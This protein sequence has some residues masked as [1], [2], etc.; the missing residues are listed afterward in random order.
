MLNKIAGTIGSRLAV[1]LLSLGILLISAAFIGRVGWGTIS[2]IVLGIAIVLQISN[3]IGGGALI[4]LAPR[5]NTY[6]LIVPAYIWAIISAISCSLV[7]DFFHLIPKGYMLHV[8]ILS[9]L[10]CISTSNFN[11]LL[12]KG[13]I[14]TYNIIILVQ[15]ILLFLALIILIF[16]L[17]KKEVLS[18]VYSLYIA[19]GFSFIISIYFIFKELISR[20]LSELNKV[21]SQI[22]KYGVFTQIANITQQLN[23]R[24]S[25]YI[26][27]EIWGPA[28]LGV[29]AI[30]VQ[31]SEW[32]W[33]IPKSIAL[34]QYSAISNTDDA[35]YSKRITLAFSKFSFICSIAL[36]GALILLP[37]SFYT[38]F[39][40]DD[41]TEIKKVILYLAPGIAA[42]SLAIHYSSYFS[43]IGKHRVNAAGSSIGLV[44]TVIAGLLLIPHYSIAGG[45]ATATISYTVISLFFIV[46]MLRQ[47]GVG[48]GDLLPSK[49]D[50][51]L[52]QKTLKQYFRKS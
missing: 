1:N 37:T 28:A 10:H 16:P 39:L 6:K 47:K 43:G 36:T 49:S 17:D 50:V 45:A 18:Y 12:G 26:V 31:L 32:V 27:S 19:Y 20:D 40:G 9:L 30:G 21:I 7:L 5:I 24:A 48:V 52:A 13:K 25:Y 46:M 3:I 44:A 14:K 29:F 35:A 4:F 38:T 33:T 22:L 2:L 41:Y 51:H 42:F 34:V 8:M 11:I 23:Y 15:F